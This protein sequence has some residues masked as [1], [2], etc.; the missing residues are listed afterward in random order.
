MERRNRLYFEALWRDREKYEEELEKI[1]SGKEPIKYEE[2]EE[3]GMKIIYALENGEVFRA[4][5]NLPN[6]GLIT[7]LPPQCI[8][9]VPCFVEKGGIRP[10]WWENCPCS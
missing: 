1:A 8:V 2:S 5:I 9:E 6:G 4:N 3:Y 7:N 10:A